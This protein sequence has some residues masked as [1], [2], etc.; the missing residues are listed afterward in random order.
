VSA[1]AE[2]QNLPISRDFLQ[3]HQ[4][5]LATL[6]PY[7]IQTGESLSEALERSQQLEKLAKHIQKLEAQLHKK[8][9]QFNRRVELNQQLR[10]AQQAHTALLGQ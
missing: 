8:T 1:E 9:T 2:R 6:L 5:L 7:P 3:L 4:Q 10:S